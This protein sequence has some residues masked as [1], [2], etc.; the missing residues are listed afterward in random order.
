M[1]WSAKRFMQLTAAARGKKL[2]GKTPKCCDFGETPEFFAIFPGKKI[3]GTKKTKLA[4]LFQ[5]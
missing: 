5:K 3:S 4:W 1:F 2:S